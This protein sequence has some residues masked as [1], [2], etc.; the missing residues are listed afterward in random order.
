MKR[1]ILVLL[2]ML[3]VFSTTVFATDSPLETVNNNVTYEYFDDGSYIKTV[4]RIDTATIKPA[5][6]TRASDDYTVTGYKDAIYYDSN[7]N[8]D[9]QVTIEGVFLI[10]PSNVNMSG[11]CQTATLHHYIYDSAW[12]IYNKTA[13]PITNNACGTCTMKSKF[14][15]ITTHTV[16]V[17]IHVTCDS[18]G[19]LK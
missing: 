4:V 16:D 3:T 5:V 11:Y 2:V 19:N 10:V 15:G 6:D 9:W 13:T 1:F 8:M 12:H 17:D 14:L 18:Y 7:N